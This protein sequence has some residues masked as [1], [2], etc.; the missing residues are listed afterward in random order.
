MS[1]GFTR[2]C[3]YGTLQDLD[4]IR[5]E[6][7]K[8][9]KVD[10]IRKGMEILCQRGKVDMIEYLTNFPDF[11]ELV[12]EQIRLYD[13]KAVNTIDICFYTACMLGNVQLM[14][15]F[16]RKF[17][18]NR[19]MKQESIIMTPDTLLVMS[20]CL[21]NNLFQPHSLKYFNSMKTYDILAQ[22]LCNIHMEYQNQ[23][24][25]DANCVMLIAQ[26]L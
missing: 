23:P 15:L 4:Y 19:R 8:N 3:T 7:F 17:T 9:A 25:F 21:K 20:Y 24:L 6:D 10:T 1:C 2:L 14:N 22:I 26:F 18:L 5:S 12:T 16:L 11:K 13:R